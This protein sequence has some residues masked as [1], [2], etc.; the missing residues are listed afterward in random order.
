MRADIADL[1]VVARRSERVVFSRPLHDYVPLYFTPRN[2]MLYVRRDMQDDIVILCLDRN[3]IFGDGAVFTDGNAASNPTS[4]FNDLRHLGSLDWQCIRAERWN[5]FEDGRRKRC[6]EVLVPDH[7]PF[8]RVERVIVRTEET[9]YRLRRT[10]SS[11]G[12]GGRLRRALSSIGIGA[13]DSGARI[14]SLEIQSGWYF[15]V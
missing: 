5:E 2:P 11:N 3:L 15:N 8:A 12:I 4:F 10:L 9:L 13:G 14:P 6:A 1:N 7:I